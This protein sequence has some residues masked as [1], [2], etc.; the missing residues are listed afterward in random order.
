MAGKLSAKSLSS[1][2]IR[3]YCAADHDAVVQLYL[4]GMISYSF[5]GED[6]ASKTLWGQVRKASVDGDL[7]DIDDSYS[8]RGGNFWVAVVPTDDNQEEV[9]G[10]VGLQPRSEVVGELRRLSVKEG[11]RRLGLGRK[12]LRHVE[13]WASASGF[14]RVELSTGMTMY[15]AVAF[16]KAE[17]YTLTHTTIFQQG[18]QHEEAHFFFPILLNYRLKYFLVPAVAF[19]PSLNHVNRKTMTTMD[20]IYAL[21]HQGETIYGFTV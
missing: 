4:N 20:V 12:L 10:M 3:P 8:A 15:R 19:C 6:E 9:V 16:Y 14:E 2:T 11:F 5:E 13:N 17:G 7:A 21:K 18:T 1:L